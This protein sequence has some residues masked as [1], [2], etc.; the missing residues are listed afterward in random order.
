MT[1]IP[2]TIGGADRRPSAPLVSVVLPA[3]N[4]EEALPLVVSAIAK[5]AAPSEIEF[6]I[7]D[8]GSTDGTWSRIQL[9]RQS[10]CCTAGEG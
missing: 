8:D 10:Q 7:V 3:H 9:M 1:R 5:A 2:S 6:V 4:E